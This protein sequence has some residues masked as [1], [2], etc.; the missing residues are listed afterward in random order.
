MRTAEYDYIVVGAGSAGCVVAHRLLTETDAS[1][2]LLEAG[3][4]D[5]NLLIHMPSGVGK[6]I[7]TK[8]WPYMTEPESGA[9]NRRMTLAQ[10]KLMGGSSSVNGMIYIRGHRQDYDAWSSEHGCTGWSFD[11]LLPY[12]RKAEANESLH[13]EF[14]ASNG[15]LPISENRYR[16]PLSMAFIR[17]GQAKGLNYVNDFN[18][19]DPEGV[20]FFQ[21]TTTSR[22]RR[23][24]TARTYLKEVRDNPRLRVVT[25]ALVHRVILENG[26]A[27]GIVYSRKGGT[28]ITVRANA[29]VILSAGAIGSPK[30]LMLSGIGPAE[31]LAEHGIDCITDQP[32]GDH[33]QDH[34]HVSIN[35]TTHDPISLYG[36][37][38]GWAA[39]KNGFQWLAFGSGVGTSNV[40]EAAAFIDTCE[41]GRPDVEFHFLPVL[42]TWDDPDNALVGYKHGLTI[43]A[44]LLQPRSHGT[45]RLASAD[46][47][48][49]ASIRAGY[50][51]HSDDVDC[52]VRAV[53]AALAFLQSSPL[54]DLCEN[55]IQPA[56]HSWNDRDQIV[57]FIRRTLKTTYHPVGT[58]RMGPSAND[59]VVD[60]ECRVHGVDNL[61]VIDASVFP[62]VPSGNTNAPTIAVAEK[63]AAA[64]IQNA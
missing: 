27:C 5:N 15:P 34:P 21:T 36:Q 6:V 3:G 48:D 44:G 14:H 56:P 64:V 45:V 49:L 10:G 28:A 41:Q 40:L 53:E 55:I 33:L 16:H 50:L 29:E 19:S 18:G 30:I 59:A 43:K 52:M 62:I 11:E 17:A 51:T 57:D 61:R 37:E 12:F 23:A 20:G 13:N 7:P 24:S 22:G 47:S 39:L 25:N 58:C 2:L 32:V 60:T 8:T 42:D 4:S 54:A 35:A 1:V 9:A 63:A 31:H 26:T 38:S 46:A